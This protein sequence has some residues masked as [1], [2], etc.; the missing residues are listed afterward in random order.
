[1]F[2]G[3][4]QTLSQLLPAK[5]NRNNRSEWLSAELGVSKWV[6]VNDS[7]SQISLVYCLSSLFSTSNSLLTH[8]YSS[9][10][11]YYI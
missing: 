11:E 6:L 2:L 1:M 7:H 10:T 4:L 3:I 8:C 5:W 9:T